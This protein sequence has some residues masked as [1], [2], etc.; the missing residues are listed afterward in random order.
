AGA[1]PG[2]NKDG[3]IAMTE[4]TGIILVLI[5]KGTFW[6]GSQNTDPNG[7]NF[8]PGAG[9]DE[10]PQQVNIDQPFFLSKYEMTQGQWQRSP[11]EDKNPSNYG[12]G[13]EHD[14]HR[15]KVSLMNPVEQV[16]WTTATTLLTKI[17]LRLP[18]A[19][20]WE[21]AA[22]AGTSTIFVGGVNELSGVAAWGNIAGVETIGLFSNAESLIR[23]DFLIHGP[24]GQFRANSFGLFDVLGNVSE[25]TSTTTRIS[26]RMMRGGSYS[27][28]SP[29]ARVSKWIQNSKDQRLNN[30]GLRPSCS[31]RM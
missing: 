18:T 16:A 15:G 31:I 26:Q 13:W 7:Q 22:R 4:K 5:P 28:S 10:A 24:V 30:L 11:A 3:R 25:W 21:Y 2:R 27:D 6:M 29:Y 20:Q 8:D 17:G 14:H 9:P 23:D 19:E 12:V 1:I